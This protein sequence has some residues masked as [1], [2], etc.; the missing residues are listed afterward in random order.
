MTQEGRGRF[1]GDEWFN[2][3][4][5]QRV[6]VS[7]E[8][9]EARFAR[10]HKADT[11]EQLLEYVRAFAKELGRTP[12]CCEIIGG[13]YISSRF[14][15]WSGVLAAA[16]LP[17]PHK[18]PQL[19]NRLIYKR[20]FK[21]QS[22]L[23]KQE[24]QDA[25]SQRQERREQA[26]QEAAEA[27]QARAQQNGEWSLAHQDDTDE[28]L[29]DYLRQCAAQLGHSPV[30][31]EVEGAGLIAKRFVT[32][33]LALQLAGLEL[34]RDMKPPKASQISDYRRLRKQRLAAQTQPMEA[35]SV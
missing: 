26:V 16:G 5:H 31:S 33:P 27:R 8:E 32:W 7:L 22:A 1:R 13:V 28:Q 30:K 29:L 3:K 10:E 11:D 12:N 24:R 2:Q 19:K 23:F 21:R 34:P 4:V 14:G 17:G 25:E 9:Q 35:Q 20:E 18:V 15:N 6:K